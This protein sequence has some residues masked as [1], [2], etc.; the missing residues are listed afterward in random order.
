MISQPPGMLDAVDGSFQSPVPARKQGG[1]DDDNSSGHVRFQQDDPAHA[2]AL[3]SMDRPA[4][5]RQFGG[6][7]A[8]AGG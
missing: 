4:R 3:A 6:L 5:R 7:A 1:H 2:Q 8:V